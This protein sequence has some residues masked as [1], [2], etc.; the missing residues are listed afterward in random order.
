MS[1][2]LAKAANAKKPSHSPQAETARILV[3]FL[4]VAVTS[5]L[6]LKGLYPSGAYER[7]RYLNLLVHRAIHPE[8]R[9]YIY[10]SVNELFAFIEKGLVER[11]AVI[12]FGCDGVPVEK[13]VFKLH[14]SQSNGS[15]V[16]EDQLE[17]SL[18]SLLVKLSVS[19]MLTKV[20]PSDCKWEIAA[21]FNALP[22]TDATKE[23]QF[24]K[25]TQTKQWCQPSLITP[26][27]SMSS[28]SVALQLYVEHQTETEI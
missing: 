5:I 7:R 22:D 26:I 13:F 1:A 4:E 25:P 28:E 12:F 17:S 11:I 9:N 3:E 20:L 27:K 16:E 21:Y 2:E 19:D 23:T 15:E 24:W 6:Y 8:L 10:S 18:G 14:V